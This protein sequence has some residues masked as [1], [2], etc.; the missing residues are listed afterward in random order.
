M[1]EE[2]NGAF[3]ITAGT[4]AGP[5]V[6]FGSFAVYLLTLAPEVTFWDC[7]E[8][9]AAA[10]SLGIPHPPGYPLFCIIGKFF[11]FL[12][13]GSVVYRLNVMSAF[14]AA[15]TVYVLFLTLKRVLRG[16]PFAQWLSA[17]A[18]LSFAFYSY[19]WGV[20]VVAA[21]RTL[22]IFLLA[23]TAWFLLV[24]EESQELKWLYLSAF[25]L[26]F[27]LVSHESAYFVIPAFIIYHL[28]RSRTRKASVIM[29]S[30][31]LFILAWSTFLYDPVRGHAGPIIDI[32]RPDTLRNIRWVLKWD[33]YGSMLRST[34]LNVSSFFTGARIA[35]GAATLGIAAG[36]IYPL[37]KR[38]WLLFMIIAGASFYFCMTFLTISAIAVRKM[39]L[40]DKYYNPVFIFLIPALAFGLSFLWE[41]F[42]T[43]NRL[44]PAIAAVVLFALPAF[45]L[46]SNYKALD[47]SRNFFAYDLAGNELNSLKP[48]S[49]IFSWG[50]NGVFP[51]WYRQD[52]EK[53]RDDVFFIHAELLSYD[54]YME[55]RQAEMYRRYGIPFFPRAPLSDI[56][57]NVDGM[58]KRLKEKTSVYFD[59]SSATQL[60]IPMTS[61]IPQGVAW[62]LP[63]GRPRPLGRIWGLYNLR[64]A[65][66]DSTNKAFAVEG[67]LN[68]YA[69]EA[70]I[71][72]Q[73]TARPTEALNAY[74]VAKKLGF[75]N[76]L[77]DKWAVSLQR[78]LGGAG[79]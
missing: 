70:A 1:T 33:R 12:P 17:A 50:D 16:V 77:L 24:F 64:G 3:K 71:W 74:F 7:G 55:N 60:K 2:K 4:F 73:T 10:W 15:G 21:V 72:S 37:R 48:F 46:V 8:L 51:V 22:S 58:A 52:V 66:D 14:F 62:M 63:P 78:K 47:N 27:S 25:S 54:W 56:R 31:G 28:S 30:A 20:S 36:V 29:V 5:A 44:I 18:A 13:L 26:G 61:L 42:H 67:V 45:L 23:L 43:K 57:S 34:L 53:Y 9:S 75:N 6:F 59:F 40:L 11:T 79:K 69:W 49:A 76:K 19:F 39:G 68:I 35:A 41:K 65:L 32:G 38:R